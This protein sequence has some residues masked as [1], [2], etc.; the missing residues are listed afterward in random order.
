M[1]Y[2]PSFMVKRT[3]WSII[4]KYHRNMKKISLILIAL[5][6]VYFQLYPQLSDRNRKNAKVAYNAAVEKIR[7]MDFKNALPVLDSAVSLDPGLIDAIV[8]RAKVKVELGMM[9]DAIS[10]F[11]SAAELDPANGEADFYLAYLTFGTDTSAMVINRLKSAVQKGYR[12]PQ[13]FYYAGLYYLNHM[14]YNA[15]I[16]EFSSAIELNPSYALAY[17][18]RGTARKLFGDLQGAIYDYRLAVNADHNFAQAY[19]N[20]GSVKISLGDYSGALADYNLALKL[21]PEFYVAYNNRGIAKYYLGQPDSALVDFDKAISIQSDYLPS[22]NNKAA[23]LFKNTAYADALTLFNQVILT[24]NSFG[25]A[26]LNRGLVREMTGDLSGACGD[27][28]KASG[29]GVTEAENYIK[30]CK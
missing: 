3:F 1:F 21:D 20:M 2:S 19:N 26:Y 18:D 13:A 30:E 8:L 5:F 11:T 24:D 22:V 23:C 15:A 27:W 14:D 10:D 7:T 25:K 28:K 6:L 16:T 29:L 9:P 17:H 12:Q 4:N